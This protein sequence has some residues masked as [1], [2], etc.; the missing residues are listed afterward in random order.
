MQEPSTDIQSNRPPLETETTKR[1]EPHRIAGLDLAGAVFDLDES[2]GPAQATDDLGS[3]NEAAIRHDVR[4]N[5]ELGFWGALLVSEAGTT[6]DEMRRR[7][8]SVRAMGEAS[9][10]LDRIRA[11]R[12][13]GVTKFIGL[14]MASDARE[15]MEQSRLLAEEVIPFAND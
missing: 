10:V 5:I 2:L 13:A 12:A 3:L 6:L 4:R 8:E 15:M 7:V 11:F 1:Y 9:V 14:P